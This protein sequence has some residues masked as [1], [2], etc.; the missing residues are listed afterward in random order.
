M[1][2]KTQKPRGRLKR[3]PK[4]DFALKHNMITKEEHEEVMIGNAMIYD[5]WMTN[6]NSSKIPHP[7]GT[8]VRLYPDRADEILI[9]KLLGG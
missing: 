9:N 5:G 8:R 6:L 3:D 7:M 2:K 1:F 4:A